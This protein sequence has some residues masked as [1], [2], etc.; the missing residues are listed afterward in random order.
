MGLGGAHGYVLSIDSWV[1]KEI[2]SIQVDMDPNVGFRMLQM[3]LT[4]K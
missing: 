2:A 1:S 3:D 4:W